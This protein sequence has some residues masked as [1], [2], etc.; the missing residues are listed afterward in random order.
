MPK[1]S[2]KQ[3]DTFT[4]PIESE[5]KAGLS[6]DPLRTI[7]AV[8]RSH[9][10]NLPATTEAVS[11]EWQPTRACGGASSVKAI[12]TPAPTSLVVTVGSPG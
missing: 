11:A 8:Y 2:R 6:K 4:K 10:A 3:H 7:L 12:V 1:K 5:D 9:K